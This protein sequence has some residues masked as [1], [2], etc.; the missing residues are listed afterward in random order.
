LEVLASDYL[1]LLLP[2][3]EIE[4]GDGSLERLVQV[5]EATN[6]GIVH[7]DFVEVNRNQCVERRLIDYQPGSIRDDFDFGAVVLIS[8]KAVERTIQK[9]G[10]LSLKRMWGGLYELRLKTSTEFAVIRVPEIL[11]RRT[12]SSTTSTSALEAEEIFKYVDPK[13]RDYQLEMEIVATD[14]LKRIAAYLE[15]SFSP[16]PPPEADYPTTASIIIPVRN[17]EKTIA[18][19]VRSALG[20]VTTFDFNVI[21][22]DNH[23]TDKTTEILQGLSCEHRNLIHKVPQR[24]DLGIG[25]CWNEAVYSAD[26]GLFAVQLDSDDLYSDET[27]LQKIIAK[28]FGPDGSDPT[29]IPLPSLHEL[30]AGT[31]KPKYAMVIGSYRT[32]NFDLKEIPPGLVDHREW[33]RENGRNNALRIGGFGAPRAYYVPALRRF[34]FPNESYGEDY[35]VCLRMSREYEIGRIYEP[36]YLARRW[37]DNSDRDLPSDVKARYDAYKDWLRTVEIKARQ[38]LNMQS[39]AR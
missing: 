34:G 33:T 24:T 16:P 23:S 20:Q 39:V 9:H 4:L 10:S 12:R 30:T 17:R 21:V 36:L 32:V 27:V 26:C 38:S 25:G 6:A 14:H 15:P 28:F 5:A 13:N 19:A 1:C 31:C 35:A 18:D 11:Y 29:S 22:V 3:V 2:G 37:E 8:T 7:S